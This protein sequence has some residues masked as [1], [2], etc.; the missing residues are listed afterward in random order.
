V[1]QQ[2]KSTDVFVVLNS[3]SGINISLNLLRFVSVKV[4]KYRK[5]RLLF[6]SGKVE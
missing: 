1:R 3:G 2:E 6:N 5:V 4:K